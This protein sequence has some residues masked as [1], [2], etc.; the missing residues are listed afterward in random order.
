MKFLS[1]VT[2]AFFGFAMAQTPPPPP[3]PPEAMDAEMASLMA[4]VESED[5]KLQVVM[6]YKPETDLEKKLAKQAEVYGKAL[7]EDDF[8][9]S[10]AMMCNAYTKVV[11]LPKYMGKK[12]L[13]L[14]KVIISNIIVKGETC[15]EMRGYLHGSEG[16]STIGAL[17]IPFREFLFIED[18][19]WR[20]F[21]NPYVTSM[22]IMH[23]NG[24]KIKN[25][26]N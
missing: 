19:E 26:C 3:K 10:H 7:V 5:K 25:P 9:V 17:K 8:K 20:I 23:P 2:F 4:K 16:G 18:G 22:G 13:S 14:S 15:A 24:R 1:L 21:K 6:E 11:T 12:R